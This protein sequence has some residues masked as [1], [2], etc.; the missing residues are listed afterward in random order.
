MREV[1]L[2]LGVILGQMLSLSLPPIFI[3]KTDASKTLV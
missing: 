2:F 1:L 3:F